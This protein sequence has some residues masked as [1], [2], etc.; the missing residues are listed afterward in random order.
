LQG[1][2]A[3]LSLVVAYNKHVVYLEAR[4]DTRWRDV[5]ASGG[6][7]VTYYMGGKAWLVFL[8]NRIGVLSVRVSR[9]PVARPVRL[10]RVSLVEGN[11]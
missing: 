9:Q 10:R 2:K 11:V 7:L 4:E 3:P 5:L 1:L 6:E 8:C